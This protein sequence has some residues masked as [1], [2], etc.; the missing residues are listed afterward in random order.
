MSSREKGLIGI[1]CVRAENELC[2]QDKQDYKHLTSYKKKNSNTIMFFQ[3][4][5]ISSQNW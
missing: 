1:P 5:W 4:N 2:E 3:Q